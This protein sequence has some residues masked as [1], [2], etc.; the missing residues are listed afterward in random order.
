MNR[1]VG[2]SDYDGMNG[3]GMGSMR[4]VENLSKALNTGA[5]GS[6]DAGNGGRNPLLVES[7][8]N[9]LKVLTFS[10]EHV[11]LWKK[12][13]KKPAYST[14]EEYNQ[15]LSY[16]SD[17]GGFI[18]EGGLPDTEDSEYVRKASFVKFLGTTREVTHPMMLVSTAH[19]DVVARENQNGILWMMKKLEHNLFWGDSTLAANG[20]E[21]VQFD[22]LN[23]LIHP[24]NT[25][26]LGGAELKDTD[27]NRGANLVLQNYGILSDIYLPFQVLARFSEQ[28]FPKERVIMPTANGLNAGL[29]VNKFQTAGGAVE[30]NP[31]IFLQ[32]TPAL[33]TAPTGGQKSPT[34]PASVAAVEGTIAANFAKGGDKAGAATYLYAVT[35]VNN[36][37]ESVPC[38]SVSV[39]VTDVTKAVKLTITAA[40]AIASKAES[41]NI[42]RSEANGTK[43]FKIASIPATTNAPG[44]TIEFNDKNDILPNTYTLFMGQFSEDVFAFKQLCPMLKMDLAQIATSQRWL[45]LLYGTPQLFAPKKMMKF[46]NVTAAM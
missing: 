30:F 1:M 31:D 39:A 10:D 20:A 24:D 25:I 3:F 19:G 13:S 43:L 16:G 18:H 5:Y 14:V 2:L 21:G 23:K 42:Y 22:G 17:G 36:S 26:D 46:V 32:A 12:V 28:Y 6:P 37:G 27:I 41:Y 40:S 4:E 33:P 45:I 11:K 29:V 38:A 34:A 35:A 15:L 44:S 9:S 8:E 7:L